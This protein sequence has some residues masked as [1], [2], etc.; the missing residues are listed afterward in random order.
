MPGSK[1][2]VICADLKETSA[3]EWAETMWKELHAEKA[4][5][6]L[7]E[8]GLRK[9]SR[10]S[11][12]QTESSKKD[13]LKEG[14]VYLITG[15]AG[16]LGMIFSRWLADAYKAKLIL[17]NR[18]S[19]EDK[20]GKLEQL[21]NAGAEVMYYSA[22]VCNAEEMKQAVQAG[23]SRFGHIDGVIHAAGI[24]GG[25]SILEKEIGE[26]LK[27]LEPKVQGTLAL[28]EALQGEH[29]DFI[30][31]FS[32]SSAIIGDFGNCDYAVGNRF[33]MS[34]GAY[35]NA[36][37]KGKTVVVNWP[38]W[39]SEGMGFADEQSSRMYLKSSGQRLLESTEG[40]EVFEAILRQKQTQWLVMT[41]NRK[42]VYKFL[43]LSEETRTK[44]EVKRAALPSG[45]G[46]RAEMSGWNIK[47]CVIW[48][49]KDAISQ[50]LRI[51]RD[52]LDVDEN[53][54]D[55]GFDSVSLGE[56]ADV[57]T[58]YYKLNITPDIFFSYPTIERLSQYLLKRYSDDMQAFYQ[59]DAYRFMPVARHKKEKEKAIHVKK[60]MSLES[61]GCEKETGRSLRSLEESLLWELKNVMSRIL[62]IPGEKLCTDENLADFGFDS[63]SLGEFAEVLSERYELPIT[64]DIF[65]SYPTI[66]SLN[67]YLLD[68]YPDQLSRFYQDSVQE[69]SAA[70]A[71]GASATEQNLKSKGKKIRRNLAGRKNTKI[72]E[73]DQP[74]AIIGISGRFP[75]ARNIEEFWSILLEGREV[76]RK[77]P[78]ERVRWWQGYEN[79]GAGKSV[80]RKLGVIPGI[81]EFDPLFFELSPREAAN[82]DPRQ[83]ILLQETWKA[84]EDAGYG[85]KS[86]EDE[87]IG[88]FVGIED[89]DYKLLVDEEAGITS[90]HNAILAARLS[91][92]LNLDGPNMAINT[93]CSSGLV[94]VHQACQS[95]RNGECDTAIVAGANLLITSENY[96][97]MDK[98]GMLSADGKCYAFDKRANG[99]VP[100]EAVA[101]IVLKRLSKAESDGNPVYATVVGSGINYDGKTNGITAPSGRSQSRL[102]KEVYDRFHIK[103]EDM[104]Y[105]V[106]HGTG[107]KLGDP[108]E[109]N[110][111]AEAFK[112]YTEERSYCALTSTKPNI[113]HTLAASGIVSLISLVMSLK[114]ETIPA[115]IN[116]E[117][118]ND[119]IQWENSPFF[120]NR[121]NRKWTDKEGKNR[122]G[123]V[124]SFGMSGTN[125]HVVL[126]SYTP[127]ST[128]REKENTQ[129][130]K[131]YYLLVLSAKTSEALQ[132]K[133]HEMAGF[134][135]KSQNTGAMD[136]AKISYTLMEGR[137]HFDHRCAVVVKDREDAVRILRQAEE[138]EK[139][140][141]LFKGRVSRDFTGRAVLRKAM[142]DI[143]KQSYME[144]NP[145]KYKENLCV[146]AEFYC[147]GY[148]VSADLFGDVKFNKVN[149]PSYPFAKQNYWIE[150]EEFFQPYSKRDTGIIHPLLHQ[151]VSSLLGQR[152]RTGFTSHEFFIKDF[153]VKERRLLPDSIYLE[154]ARM[155]FADAGSEIVAETNGVLIQ[156]IE[157]MNPIS[158]ELQRLELFTGLYPEADGTI[159]YEIFSKSESN[160]VVHCRGT[161]K[162]VQSDRSGLIDI[163]AIKDKC[164]SNYVS[165]NKWN[166]VLHAAGIKNGEG[167]NALKKLY[168]G[169]KSVLAELELP[170]C[171]NDSKGSFM[172]HPSMLEAA[173]QSVIGLTLRESQKDE[174]IAVKKP[175]SR[176]LGELEV[177]NACTEK[178]WAYV[179][180]TDEGK[181]DSAQ[182]SFQQVNIT[183][184]NHEGDV[185]IK[186]TDYSYQLSEEYQINVL[187]KENESSDSL[188]V[189]NQAITIKDRVNE[190]TEENI[191]MIP[192]WKQ[193][194]LANKQK[195]VNHM[196]I[197][198]DF[199]EGRTE[200]LREYPN[201]SVWNIQDKEW[202]ID[203]IAE[204][205]KKNGEIDHLVWIV[206]AS[207][208]YSVVSQEVVDSQEYGVIFLFKMIKALLQL[209][210]HNKEFDLT[211]ITSNSQAVLDDD[212]VN[213]V[214]AGINGVVGSVAKEFPQWNIRLVDL[215]NQVHWPVNTMLHI[216]V[217]KEGN[218]VAYRKNSWYKMQLVS[219]SRKN[220]PV[221]SVYREGGVYVVIGGAGGIGETWSEYMIRHYKAN[222]IWIGRRM[223]NIE[224]DKKIARL[225]AFGPAPRYISA[226]ATD[227]ESLERAYK[228]IK[229]IYPHV[230][231]LVHSAIGLLDRS[232]SE[233]DVDTYKKII[234][235]KIDA[236][237]YMAKVFANEPLDFV[238]Y[239]SSV[240]SFNKLGGQSGY[241]TGCTFEDGFVQRLSR[242][243]SC[244]VKTINWGYWGDIGIGESLSE[245]F[246][247]RI[248]MSG[249]S[250]INP[251]KAMEDLD[252]IMSLP[253]C[254]LLY[255]RGDKSKENSMVANGMPSKSQ[256]I[257]I[258]EPKRRESTQIENL[259]L[260]KST[261]YITKLVGQS[262]KIPYHQLDTREDL[263]KYGIDSIMVKHLTYTFNQVFNNIYSTLF[264]ECKSIDELVKYL[265][266]NQKDT[267][268]NLFNLNEDQSMSVEERDN[269]NSISTCKTDSMFD[270]SRTD[271]RISNL[272]DEDNQVNKQGTSNS[273]PIAIIGMSARLPQANDLDE[274]W[275]NL[276]AGKDSITEIPEERWSLDGF[277]VSDVKK[278]IEQG[279]SYSKWGG[280]IDGF[281][282]FDPLFFKISPREA[283]TMDPQE[284]L[285]L[286]ECWKT[287][288]DAGYTK[289]RIKQHHNGNVGVFIG[290]TKTGFELYGPDLWK[291]GENINLS[292][293]FSSV[294]NRISYIFDLHGPSLPID[295][296]CSS[297]L[298]AIHEACETIK[299]G[300]CE[301]AIAGGVNVY[302]H[303]AT[304]ILLCEKKM[305][306]SDGK[307]KSFGKG[308]NGFVPGEGAG[309]ILLKPLAKAIEDGDNIYGVI[310]GTSINHGGKTNGYTVPNP[311]AQGELIRN[312]LDK[313]GV[314]ARTVSYIEAHGTGTELGDPIEIS[315]LTQ[316]FR[317]DTK[318]LQFCSIGS[319]KS[320]IGHLESAA[321]IAGLMKIV[322][323]MKN[324]QIAPSLHAEELN[325]HIDFEDSPFYVQK[326][327]VDWK[328]PVIEHNGTSQEYPRISGVSSFG[329][330][331]ANA[332]VILEEY[333]KEK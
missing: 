71:E 219:Y 290:I 96:N 101:V 238:V 195:T 10:I 55:L 223:R 147:L 333:I 204:K 135:E 34:Y 182:T 13:V 112:D 214:H 141:D 317:S 228:Q 58:S 18:S 3:A 280:F 300:D 91:Y 43:G 24:E 50:I 51:S 33:L 233:L 149:L 117:Q 292:T 29:L 110:A 118:V 157:W 328:R 330:G 237:V 69:V 88:M 187:E 81:A 123:A 156:N 288:E 17:V 285:I 295:T 73:N 220:S 209:E 257:P 201:A 92:F 130:D 161:G 253:E 250:P 114:K 173:L 247:I 289:E 216:P 68:R 77:L 326:D 113:G 84:L 164:N 198:G 278:A 32:S 270:G 8:D 66:D 95:L 217:D 190:S 174:I 89:G 48:E 144:E 189:N 60:M 218:A 159:I 11:P 25:G 142:E 9:V 26:Y 281:A 175:L 183:L 128:V 297:S 105:I 294:A 176:A 74:I 303:P 310:K 308:A 296:M 83:R 318:D 213:P 215:E 224:I 65:F 129:D 172:L 261:Q 87:K 301:I 133:I 38:L 47:Q 298:S 267:L 254:Q 167:F 210:Y 232:I 177:I 263:E 206:P 265:I 324:G 272:L 316:A 78:H 72:K 61:F 107:T 235:I 166:R 282:D 211:V 234:G 2:N 266:R 140:P 331:G 163:R 203:K 125:A 59:K 251:K 63:V 320:N 22:D 319:A 127:E 108:I 80:N 75:D 36:R 231:G 194:V 274:F 93:A 255:M 252:F 14:G 293:S 120:I 115:S 160:P 305:L 229:K 1:V 291:Q 162:F 286:Q 205:L 44:T 31:Y 90:N 168:I 152:Y 27:T 103:A 21:Q 332:H 277:Y 97:S 236:S 28:E 185:I 327:L 15:G 134:L 276:R 322:L 53:L 146:L 208:I 186:L 299:R 16:G 273:M 222:I 221:K 52:K 245:A 313:S 230:S 207:E 102:I 193:I 62:R 279:K 242:E 200:L 315:G 12:V 244:K 116:C 126:Q 106:T 283:M 76:I 262:L 197:A 321:G 119:Y 271:R 85:S 20:K 6:V 79:T 226:D 7:Y 98:A 4:E 122:L 124:S 202:S 181:L 268:L 307:C 143:I 227:V 42:R 40:T 323:Q 155:A 19:I 212:I 240:A 302:T 57:L 180:L 260:E 192:V 249:M 191:T 264:F 256:A 275:E 121:E 151:N 138:N 199:S 153:I 148:E 284:R 145:N 109:I 37:Y 169:Q 196:L 306:S 70:L 312:A 311:T 64:P 243:W 179:T 82:I 246:K 56:Y 259:L 137:H 99:M 304:Y 269:S 39:K 178:M 165:S 287:F 54:S 329:A 45:K 154:M 314:N 132:G 111:L 136:L 184:C 188:Q 239:F 86:F 104:E 41:G 241:S 100:A 171:V 23:K 258:Q 150:K 325:S 309:A 248:S 49:L 94:A 131:P 67:K 5:S 158:D 170:S 139:L 225:S 46:R 35:R 30:C